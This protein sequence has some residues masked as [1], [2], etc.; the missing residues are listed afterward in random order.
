MWK[1]WLLFAVAWIEA[2]QIDF[3]HNLVRSIIVPKSMETAKTKFFVASWEGG[4]DAP[5]LIASNCG[6]L[7]SLLHITV[8]HFQHHVLLYIQQQ[9]VPTFPIQ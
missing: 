6:V 4:C 9:R 3:Y 7:N 2:E 1:T 8:A 5:I